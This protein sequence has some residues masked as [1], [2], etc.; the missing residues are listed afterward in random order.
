MFFHLNDELCIKHDELCI[1][2]ND[3]YRP[4]LTPILTPRHLE[5]WSERILN[6]RQSKATT[7]SHHPACFASGFPC[8]GQNRNVSLPFR[9]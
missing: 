3:E 8:G 9:A 6:I 1:K 4:Q 7:V 5:V 2:K